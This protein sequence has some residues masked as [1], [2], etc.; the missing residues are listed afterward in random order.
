LDNAADTRQVAQLL[1]GDCGSAALITSRRR[2]PALTARFGASTLKLSTLSGSESRDLLIRR[3]GARR[4]AA[5]E[6]VDV[7]TVEPEYVR[8]S[9]AE[10]ARNAP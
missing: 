9:E 7:G 1:P 6:A 5:G 2:L 8:P 10:L 4:L 3:L